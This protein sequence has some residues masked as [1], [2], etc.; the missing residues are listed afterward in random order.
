MSQIFEWDTQKAGENGRKHGVSFAEASTIFYDEFARI[1]FDEEHSGNEQRNKIIGMSDRRRLLV[2]AFTE[3]HERLR[4]ITARKA[5]RKERR[6]YE[7]S[8]K[9]S[10]D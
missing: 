10:E 3:R 4:I 2:V 9:T 7:E 5:T 6:G 1:S 8:E